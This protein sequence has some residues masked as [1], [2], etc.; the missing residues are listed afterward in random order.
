VRLHPRE[1]VAN[2]EHLVL[3]LAGTVPVVC[4][5]RSYRCG[6][7]Y[8][9]AR[10]AGPARLALDDTARPGH[11]HYLVVLNV[12]RS[13]GLT[14]MFGGIVKSKAR[15]GSRDGLQRALAATKRRCEAG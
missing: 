2:L 10:T 7:D 9:G 3:S 11:A 12:A 14:G 5:G 8:H 6:L 13:D 4:R 15:S 1:R